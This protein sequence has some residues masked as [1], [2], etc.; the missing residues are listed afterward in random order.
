M[1]CDG[2]IWGVVFEMFIYGMVS[3]HF[4]KKLKLRK[5]YLNLSAFLLILQGLVFSFVRI[6]FAV[7]HYAIAFFFFC[8]VFDNKQTQ[9]GGICGEGKDEKQVYR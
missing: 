3:F 8:L 7:M 6:Q 1:S 4:Y 9:N 2:R 5:S